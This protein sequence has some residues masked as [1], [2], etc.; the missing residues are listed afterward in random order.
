L[1]R[2]FYFTYWKNGTSVHKEF[3]APFSG[4]VLIPRVGI[5]RARTSPRRQKGGGKP[6]AFWATS[7]PLLMGQD[8][9]GLS[10]SVDSTDNNIIRTPRKLQMRKLP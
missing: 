10:V 1:G 3:A 9:K 6:V 7:D 4:Q 8:L 5:N 2:R